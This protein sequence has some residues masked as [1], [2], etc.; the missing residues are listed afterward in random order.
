MLALD[1]KESE[2]QHSGLSLPGHTDEPEASLG[3][4]L[5]PC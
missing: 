2:A 5:L 3:P 1:R 4:A